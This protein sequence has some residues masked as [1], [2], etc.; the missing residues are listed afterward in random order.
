MSPWTQL[1]V[2]QSIT[3]Y[4]E[5]RTKI[6]ARVE[7]Y[8][9]SIESI[10]ASLHQLF[11]SG[12]HTRSKPQSSLEEAIKDLDR[13]F[14]RIAFEKT[15]FM[16]LLD[17]R[18]SEKFQKDLQANPPVFNLSNVQSTFLEL[19]L[20]ADQMFNDGIV[21]VFQRLSNGYKSNDVFKV[22]EKIVMERM[23]SMW[24][25]GPCIDHG[26]SSDQINDI[27]RVFKTLDGQK[28]EPRELSI[29]MNEKFSKYEDFEDD[30]FRAKAFKNGNIHLWFKRS[31]LLDRVNLIIAKSYAGNA[32]GKATKA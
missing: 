14:W 32:L 12:L 26:Y 2:N 4:C 21:N 17:A 25:A 10:D 6:V 16:Q 15:G 23:L 7:A 8:Y 30:Y 19:S 18:S 9:R 27:D 11:T 13:N 29:A 24:S 20:Q 28:H 22:S 5:H 1:T 3:D 31:D